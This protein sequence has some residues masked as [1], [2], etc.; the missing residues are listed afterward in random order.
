MVTI[1]FGA[2][3]CS[4]SSLRISFDGCAPVSPALDQYLALLIYA[5]Q[6]WIRLLAIETTTRPSR[7]DPSDRSAEDGISVAVVR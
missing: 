4:L 5:R 1:M 2:K 7:R 3:S 6:R